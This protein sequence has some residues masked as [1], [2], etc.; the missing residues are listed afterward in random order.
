MVRWTA[1][2]HELRWDK[3]AGA[4]T[5]R[6][7]RRGRLHSPGSGI[8]LI[9][10]YAEEMAAAPPSIFVPGVL[11]LATLIRS[12]LGFGEALVA[13]PLLALLVP[14]NVAAPVAVMA[15]V[16]VA[17]IV[18]AQDWHMV[19]AR[20]TALLVVPTLP[21]IPLGLILLRAGAESVVK[22]SLAALIIGFS[23]YSLLARKQGHLKDDAFAWLFGFSAGVLGGAYGMNGPPL[24]LYG[25]LRGWS[26]QHFRATLQGYFL[27][28]SLAGLCGYWIAGLWTAEVSRF[29]L[30]S[31]PLIVL[32]T[33]LGRGINKRMA[34]HRFLLYVHVGLI[35]VGVILM[36]QA[37]TR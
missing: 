23:A 35:A 13:V 25:S 20:S 1:A 12:A 27:P 7:L 26:P 22:G 15:S 37:L 34:A 33:L 29:Y 10:G 17:L 2:F 6:R 24:A 16:T 5:Q 21:G 11:F 9:P 19:H 3:K 31:L 28:A 14:I 36:F 30:F 4:I 8:L 32:A 18:L